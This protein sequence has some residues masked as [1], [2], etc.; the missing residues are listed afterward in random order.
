MLLSLKPLIGKLSKKDLKNKDKY[1]KKDVFVRQV[2]KKYKLSFLAFFFLL[3]FALP[4]FS[5][6]PYVVLKKYSVTFT[7]IENTAIVEETFTFPTLQNGFSWYLPED[8]EAVEILGSGSKMELTKDGLG[9][10][11]IVSGKFAQVTIKYLTDSL[12]EKT[13]DKFFLVDIGKVNAQEI[14]VTV[15][16]P[17]SATLKYPLTA[18]EASLQT[19]LIPKPDTITTDGKNI[20]LNWNEENFKQGKA[21]LVRYQE[22]ENFLSGNYGLYGI[23]L[24]LFI[25][26]AVFFFRK[27]SVKAEILVKET[28]RKE[29]KKREEVAEHEKE[30]SHKDLLTRNLFEEE[31]AIMETLLEA[32][33][34]ELWQKQLSLNTGISAVKLS[35]KLRN[36][37]AKGLIEKIPYGNTNKIRVKNPG[38]KK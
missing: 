38:Q 29:D 36:L 15:Q 18:P 33:E 23:I 30:P 2:K 17:E 10:K 35:R 27:K 24:L 22:P 4:A 11:V 21:I 9:R 20:I 5:Q 7:L 34:Q 32:K 19:A 25:A 37:E 6:E 1:L 14:S 16:L 31:R 13:K 8:A 12:I 26:A 28:K 3:A